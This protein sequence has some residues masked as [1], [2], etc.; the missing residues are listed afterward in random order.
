MGQKIH[1]VGLRLGIT[2]TWDSR[3]FEKKNYQAWLHEDVSIRKYFGRM[4]RAAAISKVEIERRANQA[5]VIV[6]TAKPGIII[7]KRGV[8]IDEIRKNLEKLNAKYAEHAIRNQA[9]RQGHAVRK[10]TTPQGHTQLI[11]AQR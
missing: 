1:P 10:V 6:H 5:R 9:K 4:T 3:W 7:G 2:R 11:V 8:G